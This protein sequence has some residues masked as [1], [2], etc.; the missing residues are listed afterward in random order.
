MLSFRIPAIALAMFALPGSLSAATFTYTAFSGTH[1]HAG[2]NI[3]PGYSATTAPDRTSTFAPDGG[4]YLSDSVFDSY[5]GEISAGRIGRGQATGA[6]GGQLTSDG[7]Y[8]SSDVT[9]EA[10][11]IANPTTATCPPFIRS[12]ADLWVEFIP[13][14]NTTLYYDVNW[15]GGDTDPG[16]NLVDYVDYSIARFNGFG[17]VNLY[18]YSTNTT[19]EVAPFGN[20]SGSVSLLAGT[21]Y[22]F[23]LALSAYSISNGAVGVPFLDAAGVDVSLSAV[24]SNANADLVDGLLAPVP[25]PAA[26]GLMAGALGG[27]AGVRRRR[28]G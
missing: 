18:S 17:Y 7:F 27:L 2:G 1:Y 14:V 19:G 6:T 20:D 25:L 26:L 10:E 24:Q 3:G 8:F 11:C 13:D 16:L 15:A 22:R 28:R 12:Q 21:T 5:A 23:S 9:T 4:G